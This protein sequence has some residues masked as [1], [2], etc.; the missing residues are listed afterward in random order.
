[1]FLK[2]ID[3]CSFI[4]KKVGLQNFVKLWEDFDFL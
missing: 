2:K 4:I 1:M 3:D